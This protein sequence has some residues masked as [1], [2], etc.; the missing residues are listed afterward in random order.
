MRFHALGL[1]WLVK[2]VVH[3]NDYPVSFSLRRLDSGVT[4]VKV[5]HTERRSTFP[6]GRSARSWRR[7]HGAIQPLYQ[8]ILCVFLSNTKETLRF[9]PGVQSMFGFPCNAW[10]A[11][12]CVYYCQLCH[13]YRL[14]ALNPAFW[15][16]PG[17]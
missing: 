5:V 13:S 14:F 9:K 1:D 11:Y 16:D 2:E 6:G 7:I 4:S 12:I 3:I 17:A 8:Q 10:F 15:S